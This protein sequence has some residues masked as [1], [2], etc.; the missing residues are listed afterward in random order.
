[1]EKVMK[2]KTNCVFSYSSFAFSKL[3]SSFDLG[4]RLIS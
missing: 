3:V 2:T 4:L 1:M